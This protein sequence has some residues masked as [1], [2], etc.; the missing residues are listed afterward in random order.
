MTTAAAV[1]TLGRMPPFVSASGLIL[2][3]DRVLTVY[4]PIRAEHVLPGGHLKW[5]ELPEDAVRREVREETGY[6]IELIGRPDILAGEE[7]AGEPG[8]VRVLYRATILSGELT[9]SAEGE[10]AWIPLDQLISEGGRDSA[11]LDEAA[12][13]QTP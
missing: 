4:D 9:S 6:S 5:R 13:R 7:A 8:V 12:S 3:G 10:A 1:L 11:L 2:D